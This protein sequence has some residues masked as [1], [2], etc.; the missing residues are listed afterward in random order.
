MF[1]FLFFLFIEHA[2]EYFLQGDAANFIPICTIVHIGISISY[3][4]S[5]ILNHEIEKL[6]IE[7]QKSSKVRFER[8]TVVN[9]SQNN[10]IL[11]DLDIFGI[12][13]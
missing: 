5:N 4:D 7:I 11:G 2:L 6:R 13:F 8:L 3:T 1:I 9:I 10:G 12:K